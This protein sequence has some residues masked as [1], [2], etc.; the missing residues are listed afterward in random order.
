MSEFLLQQEDDQESEQ[1]PAEMNKGLFLIPVVSAI[2]FK[3]VHEYCNYGLAPGEKRNDTCSPLLHALLTGIGSNY[4]FHTSEK[5]WWEKI[6]S[7]APSDS[8]LAS[9]L[10]L[11]SWGYSAYEFHDSFNQGSTEFMIH[12]GGMF[13]TIS[14]LASQNKQHLFIEP[15]LMETSQIFYN[16]RRV[17]RNFMYPFAALFFIYRWGIFPYIWGQ[18]IQNVYRKDIHFPLEKTGNF[19]MIGGG[20]LSHSL[21]FYWG[22]KILKILLTGDFH[23]P[24]ASVPQ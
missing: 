18:Y 6:I 21:N 24:K 15:L 11:I 13:L 8:Y 23:Q 9:I 10:P 20:L 4:L 22:S 2:G 16:L 19:L 1:I 17:H 3:I 12:G 7:D 14:L 5:T